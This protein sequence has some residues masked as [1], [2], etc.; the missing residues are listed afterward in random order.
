MEVVGP[1]KL[2]LLT[3]TRLNKTKIPPVLHYLEKTKKLIIFI[4]GLH[5]KPQG[6]GAS[7]AC[8]AGPFTT[9]TVRLGK[10]SSHCLVCGIDVGVSPTHCNFG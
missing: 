6:C 1:L 2:V 9:K 5:N 4:T 7:V 3:Q 8:P 10:H